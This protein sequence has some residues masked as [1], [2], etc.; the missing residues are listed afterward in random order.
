MDIQAIELR[1]QLHCLVAKK[2]SQFNGM[3]PEM[4][5][6][7]GLSCNAEWSVNKDSFFHLNH[8]VNH[9]NVQGS[10]KREKSA[11]TQQLIQPQLYDHQ[12]WT[13]RGKFTKIIED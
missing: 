7:F 1:I 5:E 6:S 13:L 12:V 8:Q 10:S 3:L 11:Q 4:A 2:F 9:E